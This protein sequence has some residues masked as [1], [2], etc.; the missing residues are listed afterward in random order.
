VNRFFATY[1]GTVEATNDPE[2]VGRL[3]VR[4][5]LIYGPSNA[6]EAI[7]VSDLPWAPPAGLPAGGSANSGG[8]VWLPEVGDHVWVRFLDGEPEKPI[9]EWG[10]QDTKQ[11]GKFAYFRL[12]DD[13]YQPDGTAPK[14][15]FLTR[16]GHALQF[17]PGSVVLTSAG[18]YAF[19]IS[20]SAEA[21]GQLGQRTARGYMHEFDDST[22]TLSL[23]VRNYL[24][25][26][27]Y[28]YFTGDDYR[29]IVTDEFSVEAG[30]NF[31]VKAGDL[32]QVTTPSAKVVSPHIELG[33]SASD[34]VVRLS[35][36][37]AAVNT[38]M[39][40]FNSHEHIGN[41][42]FPTSPPLSP[43]FVNPTG[44]AN[45]FSV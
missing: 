34:P 16:Y 43:L 25:N 40:V 41:M 12:K 35:D 7:S 5:P 24:G 39:Q 45:T 4:V 28:I 15:M 18:G 9:W 26:V 2:R 22:D 37:R 10:A 29:W 23:Y 3:K 6:N 8:L 20:D 33:D 31:V 13:G 19:Y 27:S 36:L 38:I 42:G 30:H 11:A 1:A 17:T 14:M 21:Q 32:A 44:S